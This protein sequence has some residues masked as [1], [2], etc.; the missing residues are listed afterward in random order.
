MIFKYFPGP[1]FVS[2][3]NI[4]YGS[5]SLKSVENLVVFEWF[6]NNDISVWWSEGPGVNSILVLRV[7]IGIVILMSMILD[8]FCFRHFWIIRSWTWIFNINTNFIGF[9]CFWDWKL[10]WTFLVMIY[11]V[12]SCDVLLYVDGPAPPYLGDKTFSVFGKLMIIKIPKCHGIYLLGRIVFPWAN[13][14]AEFKNFL[15]FSNAIWRR[16]SEHI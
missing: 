11:T 3:C 7:D 6:F 9:F 13:H 4:P 15:F 14:I 2:I 12:V 1:G 8:V 10:G 16:A 5:L